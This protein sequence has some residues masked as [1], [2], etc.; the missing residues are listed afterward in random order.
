MPPK[1]PVLSFLF[2]DQCLS[3][4]GLDNEIARDQDKRWSLPMQQRN[5][6][7]EFLR[8]HEIQSLDGELAGRFSRS[9]FYSCILEVHI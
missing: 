3:S 2:P 9:L 8:C 7:G 5:A 4:P 1:L 6:L